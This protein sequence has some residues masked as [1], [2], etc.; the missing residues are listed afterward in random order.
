MANDPES[1]TNVYKKTY[2]RRREKTQNEN[3][4]GK[5]TK[6]EAARIQVGADDVNKI[7]S[8]VVDDVAGI[9]KEVAAVEA[10]QN[11]G[12]VETVESTPKDKPKNSGKTGN[13]ILN[14]VILHTLHICI[15]TV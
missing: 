8:K 15:T 9:E 1:D 12:T 3:M 11:A 4:S 6:A 5:R 10:D 14:Y 2:N 7:V 13:S